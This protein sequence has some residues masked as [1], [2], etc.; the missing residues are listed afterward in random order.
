MLIEKGREADITQTI[1]LAVDVAAPVEQGQ[2]LGTVTFRLG[3]ELLGKYN[4]TAPDRIEPLTVK[5]IFMRII[6]AFA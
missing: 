3:D 5:I 1:D 2:V 6:S 4:L